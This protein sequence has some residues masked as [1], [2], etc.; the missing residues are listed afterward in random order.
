MSSLT[1]Q[2]I[3]IFFIVSACAKFLRFD[4]FS[5]A[6]GSYE[7]FRKARHIFIVS[8][9]IVALEA[10]IGAALV[11]RLEP[12]ASGSA[13]L[14]VL[15][16]T[17]IVCFTL[18]RGR[19]SN[20]CGCLPFGKPRPVGWHVAFRNLALVALLLAPLRVWPTSNVLKIAAFL[21][22]LAAVTWMLERHFQKKKQAVGYVFPVGS[23]GQFRG[24]PRNRVMPE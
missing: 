18:V 8:M 19:P 7:I 15:F 23:K 20:G 17:C 14:L 21:G 24:Y 1:S 3:G 6:V 4:R 11:G 13:L 10:V 9:I 2:G 5:A 16:F 22:W 12:W